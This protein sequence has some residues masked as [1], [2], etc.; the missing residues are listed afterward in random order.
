VVV[1]KV[2]GMNRQEEEMKMVMKSPLQ[3]R[4][5]SEKI[6]RFVESVRAETISPEVVHQAARHF[7]D[8]FGITLAAREEPASCIV[9]DYVTAGRCGGPSTLW[10]TGERVQP[11]DAA[12]AHGVM[13]HALDYDAVTAAHFRHRLGNR[14]FP[15]LPA[16]CNLF[17]G[18]AKEGI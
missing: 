9:M 8:T 15:A 6:G 4:T 18:E 7:I 1:K 2:G 11:E 10:V 5:A 3:D 14:H 16:H 17:S 12:L 13:S